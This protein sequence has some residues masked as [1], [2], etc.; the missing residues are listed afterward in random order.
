MRAHLGDVL[1]YRE[2]RNLLLDRAVVLDLL[3]ELSARRRVLHLQRMPTPNMCLFLT[4]LTVILIVI[5][6][7]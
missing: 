5:N 3:A 7:F 1:A 4:I 2:A 6:H